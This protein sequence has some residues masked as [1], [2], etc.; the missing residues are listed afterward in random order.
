APDWDALDASATLVD[1]AAIERG[2][3]L[4]GSSDMFFGHAE[5]MLLPG[6]AVNMGDGWETRRRRGPGHDWALLALG[7]AGRVREIEVDTEHFK[8]NAPAAIAIEACVA[9]PDATA[10]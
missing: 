6:R 7:A 5:H 3:R 8:F 4:V 2:G 9:A 10:E 1:L